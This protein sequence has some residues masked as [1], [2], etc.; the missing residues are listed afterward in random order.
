MPPSP[1]CRRHAAPP[2]L[3]ESQ[4]VGSPLQA[5]SAVAGCCRHHAAAFGLARRSGSSSREGG[6]ACGLAAGLLQ[7]SMRSW[8]LAGDAAVARRSIAAPASPPPPSLSCPLDGGLPAPSALAAVWVCRWFMQCRMR[9]ANHTSCYTHTELAS[10][11]CR[12]PRP[13]T[14]AAAGSPDRALAAFPLGNAP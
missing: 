3:T 9:F 8:E 6:L 11:A 4:A 2:L 12:C 5:R 14:S 13:R 1:C 7:L 10:D